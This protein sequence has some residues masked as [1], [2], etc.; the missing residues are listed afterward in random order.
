MHISIIASAI[1]PVETSWHA[2]TSPHS[3]ASI[4]CSILGMNESKSV[5]GTLGQLMPKVL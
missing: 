4:N 5:V 2:T 3:I 1:P